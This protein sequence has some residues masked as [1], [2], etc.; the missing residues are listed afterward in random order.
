M[1]LTRTIT[2]SATGYAGG[3][4]VRRGS[5][6]GV[7]AAGLL[8]CGGC[9]CD[10][11]EESPVR[12][13]PSTVHALAPLP[14]AG[15]PTRHAPPRRCPDDMVDVAGAFCVD[16]YESFLVDAA[17]GRELSPYYHATRERTR[18][19]YDHWAAAER[20]EASAPPVAGIAPRVPTPP[21]FQLGTDF[22]ARA[23]NRSGAVPQGYASGSLAR[24]ACIS[25]GKRLCS[26]QEWVRACRGEQDRDYP[27]GSS[28]E[29]GACNVART[30]HPAAIL[31]GK[32]SS[33]H[34]DPR[35]NLVADADGPLLR[36]TGSSPRCR[37]QWGDD[38][39]FDMVGNL[40][41]WIDDERG[42]FVGGFYARQT[43]AGC[44]A[45]VSAHPNAYF[46]YSLG[47]RCCR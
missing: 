5:R 3:A 24:S 40:D 1:R 29:P 35:L 42:R 32:A 36:S 11:A 43:R 21:A 2:P 45:R 19:S 46:D 18:Q 8:L 33:S 9:R 16:R 7:A 27:Y 12:P 26:E 37:S 25:A 14:D 39:I 31:H 20:A 4:S 23:E 47:V 44:A 6:R 13:A 38:A 34:R 22:R 10:G 17:T 15:P 28:Y 41:E 30:G